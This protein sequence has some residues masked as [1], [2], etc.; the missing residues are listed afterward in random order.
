[1]KSP[2]EKSGRTTGELLDRYELYAR[3]A[4]FSRA[5][6]NH[7]RS[8]VGLLDRFLHGIEDM[9]EVNAADFR[10]FLVDLRDRPVWRGLKNEQARH[11]SGTSIN[12]YARAIKAFFIWLN[13]EA[14]I[15][16]N[17]LAAVLAP[18]K[19][20]TLPKVYS[21]KDLRAVCATAAASIRDNAVFCLFLDSGIR[22]SE[23]GTL[24][25]GDVDTQSGTLKV[26]GKGN[27][28][29][30]AYFSVDAVKHVDRYMRQFR[31]GAGKGDFL[32]LT[33]DGQPLQARGIQSLLLR[34]GE[35]AGLE[36][37]LTPHKL[38]HSFATLSLKYGGNLEYIRKI[39][40]H[41][42]IKTTSEHI[43]MYRMRM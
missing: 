5:Q 22:L 30:F 7:M 39:L 42:D 38:R 6:L 34:L 11:L 18:R 24:K 36:E 15:P 26:R 13:V 27:K 40:G 29:R 23:L 3:A 25:I 35:K 10:R 20:K 1:M 19:P 9:R 2:L 28:E 41:T 4:G 33:K 37:R 14:I 17:P 16:S 8:C 12:T 43:S 21:E 32:F 31:H